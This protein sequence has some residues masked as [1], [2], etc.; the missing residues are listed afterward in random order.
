MHKEKEVVAFG[1]IEMPGYET[2]EG[3]KKFMLIVEKNQREPKLF[4]FPGGT[5]EGGESSSW[6]LY[7]ELIEE[8]SVIIV[9]AETVLVKKFDMGTHVVKFFTGRQDSGKP[10][11][12]AEVEEVFVLTAREIMALI[13]EKRLAPR[14][15]V[16]FLEF[17]RA[18]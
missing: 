3:E 6:A 18:E 14:H 2:P 13:S 7:R 9:P 17:L 1:I 4:K 11:A 16:A 15:D 8:T 10:E 5:A 12:C